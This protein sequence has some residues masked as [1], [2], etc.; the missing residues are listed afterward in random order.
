MWQMA[1]LMRATKQR[2][3]MYVVPKLHVCRNQGE[4]SFQGFS[5]G[6]GSRP[7]TACVLC[8]ECVKP[9]FWGAKQ[10]MGVLVVIV[11]AHVS[12]FPWGGPK[13]DE[14]GLGNSD[15]ALLAFCTPVPSRQKS[16]CQQVRSRWCHPNEG[17][18]SWHDR[19]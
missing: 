12:F 10:G 2:R 3:S 6:A 13:K 1:S 8:S 19:G 9:L 18:A 7:S 4:S 14:P 5:G 16:S 17:I 11:V 15:K